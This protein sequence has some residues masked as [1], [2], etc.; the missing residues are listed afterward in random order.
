MNRRNFIILG[1]TGLSYSALKN[2]GV[3][4]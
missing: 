4:A 1:D 2:F 3:T